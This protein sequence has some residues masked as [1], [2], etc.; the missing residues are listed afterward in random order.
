MEKKR[1]SSQV[2]PTYRRIAEEVSGFGLNLF[3]RVLLG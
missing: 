3:G 2:D 1:I